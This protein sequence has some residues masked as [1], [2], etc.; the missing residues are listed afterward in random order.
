[1]I[2]LIS[3]KHHE[4][5]WNTFSSDGDTTATDYDRHVTSVTGYCGYVRNY[6]Q[7]A[8]Q[9]LEFH[10]PSFVR[11]THQGYEADSFDGHV[12]NFDSNIRSVDTLDRRICEKENKLYKYENVS[13][14]HTED[15]ELYEKYICL[16]GNKT[17]QMDI[18]QRHWDLKTNN[19]GR[20]QNA[21]NGVFG[22]G[23]YS[24][25][26]MKNFYLNGET[27]KMAS[28]LESDE[29]KLYRH[30]RRIPEY[31]D[32][33]DDL[34]CRSVNRSHDFT[35]RSE[36]FSGCYKSEN[37]EHDYE[38]IVSSRSSRS[39]E[40]HVSSGAYMLTDVGRPDMTRSLSLQ[41]ADDCHGRGFMGY[42]RCHSY[43]PSQV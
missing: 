39:L 2:H 11:E 29:T 14:E 21:S 7:T 12:E 6:R 37:V 22:T 16:D 26:E 40:Q 20:K 18:L 36:D 1:M 25:Y 5:R 32:G 35:H 38:N 9:E 42:R 23:K 13:Y 10:F 27:E 33:P 43:S 31:E 17:E 19:F 41:V 30:K 28:S 4:S 34:S 3:D 24:K 8:D 15:Q